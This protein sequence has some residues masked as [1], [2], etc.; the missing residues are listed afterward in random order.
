L[1]AGCQE[2]H[3]A[4]DVHGHFAPSLFEALHGLERSPQKLR[5][6]LLGFFE[7]LPKRAEFP[8]IQGIASF[9]GM[10]ILTKIPQRGRLCNIL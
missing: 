5:H 3:L 8:V 6:L 7:F 9:W 10:K 1:L 4:L 2:E